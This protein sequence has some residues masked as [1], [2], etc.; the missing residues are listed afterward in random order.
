MQ[1]GTYDKKEEL[2]CEV[3]NMD[4]KA[5]RAV[6]KNHATDFPCIYLLKLGT[7]KDLRSTFNLDQN[8][9]DNLIIYKYGNSNNMERRMQEHGNDYGKMKNVKLEMSIFHVIDTK[10]L[11]EAETDLRQFFKNFRKSIEVDGRNEP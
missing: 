1:M 11:Y 7:A 9:S 3:L 2:G 4:V 6:F 5:Y 10:Y 8:I